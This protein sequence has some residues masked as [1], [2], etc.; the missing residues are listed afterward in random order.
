MSKFREFWSLAKCWKRFSW[1][2]FFITSS[3]G[4]QCQCEN[5]T[6]S[7][8]QMDAKL[9]RHP[10]NSASVLRTELFDKTHSNKV[11]KLPKTSYQCD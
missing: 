6:L 1:K 5:P 7:L 2:Y 9:A 4:Y 11:E 8:T 3:G 10:V